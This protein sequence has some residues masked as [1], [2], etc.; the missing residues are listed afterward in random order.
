MLLTFLLKTLQQQQQ[1]REHVPR[2]LLG[3]FRLPRTALPRDDDALIPLAPARHPSG[4]TSR[5]RVR[6]ETVRLVRDR[7]NVGVVQHLMEN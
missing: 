4:Q 7:V 3:C 5:H 2:F 1:Q 6:H